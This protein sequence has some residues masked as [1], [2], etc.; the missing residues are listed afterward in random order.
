MNRPLNET[1]LNS[2]R[3]TLL[4]RLKS[5]DSQDSWQ[6]FFD[7]YWRLIYSTALKAG[8]THVEAQDV[9]QDT[10]VSVFKHIP[11]FVYDPEAGS[12]K[13]WLLNLTRWRIIDQLRKRLPPSPI[14]PTR[15]DSTSTDLVNRIPDPAEDA[16]EG[17]WKDEWQRTVLDAALERTR[18]RVNPKH[19]QVFDLRVMKD[20]PAAKVAQALNMS[21]AQVYLIKCRIALVVK[22]EMRAVERGLERPKST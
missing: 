11:S 16:I 12:F 22:S 7:T 8:L 5:G 2:T 10:V 18:R 13:A 17:F 4:G 9:V 14:Q 20:L 21:V 19:Y 3:Q 6:E 15:D 1:E